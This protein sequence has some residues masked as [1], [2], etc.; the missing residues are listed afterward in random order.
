[1]PRVNLIS[2]ANPVKK[3][4]HNFTQCANTTVGLSGEVEIK[5]NSIPMFE[6]LIIN[7]KD[8]RISKPC[9]ISDQ[10]AH[11]PDVCMDGPNSVW[12][13][14]TERRQSGDLIRTRRIKDSDVGEIIDISSQRGIEYQP[15][16]LTLPDKD[17]FILWAAVRDG[18]YCLVSR[19]L[20]DNRLGD[21]EILFRNEEGIFHPRMQLDRYGDT[22]LIFEAIHEKKPRLMTCR[23]RGGAWLD[24]NQIQTPDAPCYRPSLSPG[25]GDGMWV[26]YDCYF[27]GHYQVYIQRLDQPSDP[28][29]VTVNGYQNLQTTL[30]ADQDS[31][32]WIGWV[33]NQNIAFRD[34]WWLAKWVY[35][36]KFDGKAFSDPISLQPDKDIYTHDSFQG[37]EFPEAAVDSSG[38]VWIFGQA[39]HTLYAQYYGS[40]GWSPRYIIDQQHWGSWKPRVR[41]AG[42]EIIS[43]VSMGLGGAQIQQIETEPSPTVPLTCIPREPLPVQSKEGIHWERPNLTTDSG[44]VLQMYFGDLHGHAVYSDGVGDV[45]EYYHRYRDAYGYDFACLTEHDYLDGIE[46]SRSELNMVWNHA[47]RMT[48]PGEF[49]AFCGYEWT[50]PAI[51]EHS[52]PGQSVGEGHKHIIYPGNRGPLI[53]YGESSANSG[54]KLLARFK[55]VEAL[56]IPHHTSWSG[57]DWDAHD[58]ELV[59]LVEVC[60]THGRF[61][62]PGNL[63]I[64]YRRDHVH[65]NKFVLDALNR[66]Y[67]LGFVGGSDSHGLLWHGTE[68][69]E[70]DSHV[71]AGTRVGWKEDAYRTGMTVILAPELTRDSLYEALYNRCCYATSG[72]P[73]VVDF[74][75]NQALM[76]SEITTNGAPKIEVRIRGTAPIRSVE[77]VRSGYVHA[78]LQSLSGDGVTEVSFSLKDEIIIPGES[79]YYYLRISQVDGNMAWSSP[80]WLHYKD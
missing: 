28:I 7:E 40:D 70:R 37:W 41:L 27:D 72:V 12:V 47:D 8:I 65:L 60:S 71:V 51:A 50:A 23:N 11:E 5:G 21:E 63:P 43:V 34:R 59:R 9:V 78:G 31:N 52:K 2:V 14:W 15:A 16:I 57:I 67:K 45:D 18:R 58:E 29:P 61:E 64:G 54:A 75:I 76:G 56:I 13:A 1:M 19:K 3:D 79:H 68:M 26:S 80:I 38:C 44:E 33:S 74:R 66:G 62:Y 69:A 24:F 10:A 49:V 46:L 25:P 32:L 30:T 36:R 17:K 55:G 35:L 4:N 73:I 42:S 48:V 53:S 22:W 6:E 39:S 20:G 77:L